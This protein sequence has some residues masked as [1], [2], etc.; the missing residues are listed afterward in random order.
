LKVAEY[1][2]LR[3][4]GGNAA[5]LGSAVNAHF[6]DRLVDGKMVFDYT[7]RPGVVEHSNALALMRAV[8]IN[9]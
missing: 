3:A 9:V 6:E 8:G 2:R 4:C 7:M 1:V 5:Q